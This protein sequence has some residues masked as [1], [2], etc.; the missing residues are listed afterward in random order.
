MKL[1]LFTFA[2][3]AIVGFNNC[4]NVGFQQSMNTA[5]SADFVSGDPVTND[6]SQPPPAVAV[7]NCQ[8]AQASGKL[9]SKSTTIAFADTKTESGKSKVCDFATSPQTETAAGN[10]TQLDSYLRARYEQSQKISLPAN[11]VLCNVEMKTDKQSFQYD[12]VFYLTFNDRILATNLERSLKSLKYQTLS[13]AGKTLP[14]YYYQWIDGVRNKSFDGVNETANDYCLGSAQ[15]LASCSWPLSQ[16]SGQ[17]KFSFDKSLLVNIG[18]TSPADA[19]HFGFVITGDNDP[20]SDCYHE[21]LSFDATLS[22]YL[23]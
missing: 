13:A 1:L 10:L 23:Q 12:D 14:L 9:L 19:Q 6:P 21:A 17:I 8:Q 11:A 3:F 7:A 22:Y 4:S 16:K 15:G 20:S 5:S 2:A 18:V